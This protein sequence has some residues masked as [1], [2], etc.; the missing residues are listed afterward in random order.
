MRRAM[1]GRI[2]R[3]A[4]TALLLL[5]AVSPAPAQETPAPGEL[6]KLVTRQAGLEGRVVW[7]DASANLQRLSTRDSLSGVFDRCRQANIN[8]VVVDVKALSGHVLYN[9][10]V[11][12]RLTEW[13]G[14]TYPAGYDLLLQSMLEGRRR[15]IKVYAAINVFCEGHKL[16]KSGPLYTDPTRQA[17]VY[18]VRRTVTMD[19]AVWPLA[20]GENIPLTRDQVVSADPSGGPRSLGA[21]DAAVILLGD[22]ID[23]VIDGSL[24]VGGSIT[25][26]SGGHLLL[27]RGSG[28]RWLL[29]H[30]RVGER[31]SYEAAPVI[32]PILNS[33]TEV[34]G[35]FVNPADPASREYAWRVVS[36][37]AENYALDGIVFD[38]MRFASLRTDFSPLSRQLFEEWL[39]KKLD[40]FPEDIYSYGAS[41]GSEL[42]Q[43]P[44]FKEW[45]EWRAKTI[46]DWLDKAIV[47]ARA[48]RPGIGLGVYVGSWYESYYGVGVNWARTGFSP[49]YSWMSPRYPETGYADKLS[50]LSTGCYYPIAFRDDARQ[51]GSS[52]DLT[53][54]AA[55]ELS[56]K[57][58]GDAAFVYAGLYLLDY[59]GRPEEFRRA[60]R[61]ALQHSQGVMFFDLVYLEEYGWWSILNEVFAA[62]KRAPH[63][64]AGLQDAIQ[65][66]RRALMPAEAPAPSGGT[67]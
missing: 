22:T 47:L 20:T 12:P 1:L 52:E 40:R 17:M 59:Q 44:Y 36:E 38:R 6:S 5:S 60:V 32:Q 37:L 16:L 33:P 46:Q 35:A 53:V 24:V 9:S 14:F 21:D 65:R 29:E 50:W 48:R 64:V 2:G 26:P 66:T 23:A 54:Q 56:T 62:P 27:G 57:A 13:K 25:A 19:G 7:M 45:L 15:G 4:G 42:Q 49:G 30:A 55:A 67:P 63:E 10:K 34:V 61:A 39:G 31:L 28:A 51:L 8:T 43:G 58:V 41:P 11:A 18:D 3:M